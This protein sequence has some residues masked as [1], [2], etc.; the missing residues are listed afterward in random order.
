M[1]GNDDG[2]ECKSRLRTK[3]RVTNRGI[4]S[5]H[6]Q[7]QHRRISACLVYG[8]GSSFPLLPLLCDDQQEIHHAATGYDGSDGP[9]STGGPAC[10]WEQA[11]F[12]CTDFGWRHHPADLILHTDSMR[13]TERP[14]ASTASPTF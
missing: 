6:C 2:L 14:P 5:N 3:L 13:G 11:R 8:Q 1:R 4:V 10:S 9:Q 12:L 7:Y